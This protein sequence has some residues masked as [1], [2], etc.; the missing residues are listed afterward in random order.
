LKFYAR[1]LNFQQ[2]LLTLKL[3]AADK[4]AAAA[5]VQQRGLLLVSLEQVRTLGGR[6][7][8]RFPLLLF[9]QEIHALLT[10]GL[11]VIESL[12]VLIDK[13]ASG[14]VC[15]VLERVSK[16]VQEGQRLSAALSQQPDVFPALLIGIL[17]AAE[18]TSDLPH[19]L[20]R[21]LDY[22]TRLNSVKQKV[23]SAAIYPAILV[24]VGG[25]VAA[26]LLGFVVPKFSAVYSG[27][28]RPMP[29]ASQ[30]LLDWG[31]LVGRHAGVLGVLMALGVGACAW[32]VRK[33]LQAGT[34]WRVLAIIPG[35]RARFELLEVSRL[36][37]TLG[38][39]LQGGLPIAQ[40]L[41][42]AKSVMPPSRQAAV[43]TATRHIAEGEP[44]SQAFVQ[45]GL[46]TPVALRLLRVGER[47]GQLGTMLVRTAEFYESET[48]R[49]IE[50]FSKAF[51][52]VLM[53]A[54]GLVIGM[55]VILLYMPIFD[56]VG[57]L[58]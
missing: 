21:Y 8:P 4:A 49:W 41:H 24:C 1:A 58:Q 34:W 26:F 15:S 56:L 28:G 52:P 20:A 31:A 3:D 25:A 35:T 19:A 17:Q 38:M 22:E 46:M 16:A 53:A 43:E 36:Y 40:A 14:A 42:L 18:G 55:I 33:H 23:V 50:R 47:S 6:P 29:W 7:A 51:E 44:L 12:E 30:L 48:A 54:I 39:L 9:T 32:W 27:N 57:T 37:L 13:E 45:T 10:A 2:Q 5:E 11:S